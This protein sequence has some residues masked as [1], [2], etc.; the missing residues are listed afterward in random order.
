MKKKI[1]TVEYIEKLRNAYV[2]EKRSTTDI[3][4][5]STEILGLSV[6]AGT[7]YKDIINNNIPL[8]SKSESVSMATGKLDKNK[9]FLTEDI[10]EWVDGL[11]MGD[12]YV[13]FTR[14]GY[15]SCRYRLDS[16]SKEWVQYGM[17]KLK[18]YE[19]NG[20]T[21]Y[22]KITEKTPNPI[23]VSQTL[24]HPDINSQAV[25]W[26]SG[27]N[28]TKKIPFDVRITP[29]SVMLWYLGDGSFHYE[30]NGN[31]SILRLATCAFDKKDLNEIIIP[32]LKS[33]HIE[34]DADNSKN[35]IYIHAES[36]KD[37]FNFIGWKSPIAC[38]DHKFAVPDW[39]K[40]IRL[41]EIVKNDQE[42]WRAQY[43]FKQGKIECSKSHGGKMLLFTREQANK[44]TT[45]LA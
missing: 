8:R 32:K 4:K 35:D 30:P 15:V 23:W 10:V 11:M 1:Y 12:G 2:I 37:F 7:I 13:N 39:L 18:D 31:M 28:R 6:S 25:R 41:S 16:S 14:E 22:N 21:T 43:Y 34:C 19:P 5:N 38:Y 42:K 26:Y 3:A 20:I 29:I 36:I 45:M 9:C 27:P 24:M 40:L 44:L 33:Q 17:S